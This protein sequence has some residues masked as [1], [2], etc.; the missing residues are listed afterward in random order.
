M[1]VVSVGFG[2]LSVFV[3]RVG[4]GTL[5]VVFDVV[6]VVVV[7]VVVESSWCWSGSVSASGPCRRPLRRAREL[8]HLRAGERRL[9]VVGPDAHR[10]G[11]AG[12][13]AEPGRSDIETVPAL[14][15]EPL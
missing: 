2:G 12:E 8:Q 6:V 5:V 4:L 15:P 13:L 3:V 7:V 9:H 1:V 11:A 10:D 14:A